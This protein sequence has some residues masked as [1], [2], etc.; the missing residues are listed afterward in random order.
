MDL[1][2]CGIRWKLIIRKNRKVFLENIGNLYDLCRFHPTD[3]F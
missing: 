3:D 1:S 2:S